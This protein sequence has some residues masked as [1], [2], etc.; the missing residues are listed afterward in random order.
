MNNNTIII[1]QATVKDVPDL[2]T[3]MNEL[4]YPTTVVEMQQRFE[5]FQ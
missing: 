1:R 4:G 5:L 3:L 2:A